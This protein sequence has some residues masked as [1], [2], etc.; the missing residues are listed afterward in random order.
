MALPEFSEETA[1]YV[2]GHL[3]NSVA[4]MGCLK[5]QKF[6]LHSSGGQKSQI[7]VLAGLVLGRWGGDAVARFPPLSWWSRA[8]LGLWHLLLVFLH[9]LPPSGYKLPVFRRIWKGIEPSIY[10]TQMIAHV[11]IKVN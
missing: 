4:Q 1:V 6:L 7:K 10:P 11:V 8:F 3:C 5:H 9:C 2:P